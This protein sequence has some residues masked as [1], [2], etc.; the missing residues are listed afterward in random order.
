[1]REEMGNREGSGKCR[2]SM[3]SSFG[4]EPDD[5]DSFSFSDGNSTNSTT[6]FR[7]F[8]M[9]VIDDWEVVAN[10]TGFDGPNIEEVEVDSVMMEYITISVNKFEKKMVYDPTGDT[11]E[12]GGTSGDYE[13]NS[14]SNNVGGVM[15]VTI[16]SAIVAHIAH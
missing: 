15:L 6:T 2:N 8:G 11:D 12:D 3:S 14:A 13:S 16:L 4:D 9:A 1:M 10:G 5:Q 7:M